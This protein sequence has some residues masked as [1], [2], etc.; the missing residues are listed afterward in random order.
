MLGQ[1]A[2]SIPGQA[3]SSP[4]ESGIWEAF[5]VDKK[6]TTCLLAR[7]RFMRSDQP[8]KVYQM[9]CRK[10]CKMKFDCVYNDPD[11]ITSFAA[12]RRHA[13]QYEFPR[14]PAKVKPISHNEALRF[15]ATEWDVPDGV[16][17]EFW[18]LLDHPV[19]QYELCQ[20]AKNMIIGPGKFDGLLSCKTHSK[21][22]DPRT[23]DYTIM[24]TQQTL[25]L[26]AHR[27][28]TR[29]VPEGTCANAA[30]TK[31]GKGGRY[32]Y[33]SG[34]NKPLAILQRAPRTAC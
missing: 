27:M 12:E 14:E 7:L 8:S 1:V 31:G 34:R 28:P 3:W 24:A 2:S 19:T 22:Y 30:C 23:K 16:P 13:C 5:L 25:T 33:K 4:S 11:T 10:K 29:T 18:K 26:A 21:V 6:D 20:H 15:Y 32:K 17:T 9:G